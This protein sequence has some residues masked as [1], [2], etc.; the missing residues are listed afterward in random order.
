M[1]EKKVEL[2]MAIVAALVAAAAVTLRRMKD[3]VKK[4]E[5][6]EVI[7]RTAEKYSSQIEV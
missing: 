1:T 5:L 7:R 6:A 4:K 3:P 2:E